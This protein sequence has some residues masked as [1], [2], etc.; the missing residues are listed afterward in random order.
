MSNDNLLNKLRQKNRQRANV[1]DRKDALF[2]NSSSE[3]NLTIEEDKFDISQANKSDLINVNSSELEPSES[4]LIN[5]NN[6][7][8]EEIKSDLSNLNDSESKEK[9]ELMQEKETFNLT[10]E[11]AMNKET[12]LADLKQQLNNFPNT[13][14][15][16]GIVLEE[17]IDL[18]L[19]TYCKRN[20]ITVETFLEAAWL[21]ILEK[22]TILKKVTKEATSRYNKRK[23]VGQL[24]RLIT[25]LEKIR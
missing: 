10:M 9:N 18:E 25:T 17:E 15:R 4:S 6:S 22:E 11:N 14:R 12:T 8:L 3:Q 21:I 16:S 24:R 19:T 5:V 1:T 2:A 13:R 20:G 7:E 23:K